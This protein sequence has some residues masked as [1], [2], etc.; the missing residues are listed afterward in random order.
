MT[1]QKVEQE[2]PEFM[3]VKFKYVMIPNKGLCIADI[4]YNNSDID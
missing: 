4:L 1:G 3:M 2:T